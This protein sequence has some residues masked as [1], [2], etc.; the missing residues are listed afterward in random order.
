M[1]NF[2]LNK[3][4]L[5][6]GGAGFIGSH[7]A[8]LLLGDGAKV[9]I[10]DDFSTGKVEYCDCRASLYELDASTDISYVFDN[11]KPE[12][13]MVFASLVD[14]PTAIRYPL[15]TCKGISVTV[16]VLENCV[17]F[18]V[19]KILYASSGYV[20]GNSDVIP[21]PEDAPLRP[22]NPYN[23]AKLAAEHYLSF[24]SE[25]YGLSCVSLRYAPTYGPR[26]MIGPIYDYIRC[27][28]DGR[29]SNIYGE[30][31]RDYIYVNDVARANLL[32]I[33]NSKPNY[34]VLNIGTGQ[35]I[36][37]KTVYAQIANLAGAQNDPI[38]HP[39][40]TN[41]VERFALDITKSRKEICFSPVISLEMGLKKTIDWVKHGC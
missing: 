7:T 36:N 16:N 26:R 13:V 33:E 19:Q 31:T 23:I 21:T 11:E 25:K 24:F 20:Y 8:D 30:K 34:I 1:S 29:Q 35:E 15:L 4:V 38:C 39:S 41:E 40:K 3:S 10:V 5:L 18:A 27:L 14:V 37:L 17:K 22:L 32:A 9:S 12:I 2:W 28:V 6:V